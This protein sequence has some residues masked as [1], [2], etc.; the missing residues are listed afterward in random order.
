[1]QLRFVDCADASGRRGNTCFHLTGDRTSLPKRLV[2]TRM[3]DDMLW[4]LS[5][6]PIPR[7]TV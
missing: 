4:R 1:M 3:S 2:L 7:M 6:S 5:R